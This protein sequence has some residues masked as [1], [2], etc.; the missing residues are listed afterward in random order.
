LKRHGRVEVNISTLADKSRHEIPAGGSPWHE[1][2]A[3]NPTPAKFFPD[4][5]LAPFLPGEAIEKN[6]QLLLAKAAIL[7]ELDLGAAFCSYEPNFLPEGSSLEWMWAGTRWCV[8][9]KILR[10]VRLRMTV[11]GDPATQNDESQDDAGVMGR[12]DHCRV[13]GCVAWVAGRSGGPWA[14]LAP[15]AL[16]AA[17]FRFATSKSGFSSVARWIDVVASLILFSAIC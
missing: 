17:R 14:I 6:R 7:R 4:D 10:R 12:R 15:S 13:V 1:Y 9:S 5:M 8:R 11:S 3:C 16:V 2:A